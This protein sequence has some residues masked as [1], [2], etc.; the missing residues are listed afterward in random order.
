MINNPFIKKYF[1]N[2]LWLALDNVIKVIG[3]LFV[4]VWVARYLGAESYGVLQY[5]ITYNFMFSALVNIGLGSILVREIVSTPEKENTLM[6]SALGLQLIGASIA[7]CLINITSLLYESD[8]LIQLIIFLFSLQMFANAFQPFT[9]YFQANVISKYN[10]WAESISFLISS[11]V[12]VYFILNEFPVQYIACA[13]LFDYFIKAIL[14]T[15]FFYYIK[16]SL[17]FVFKWEVAISLLKDSWVI[18]ITLFLA[19]VQNRIDQFMIKNMIGIS[20]LGIYSLSADLP[21]Y[22]LLLPTVLINSL[23]P[24]FV[25]LKKNNPNFYN[26]R[27]IQILSAASWASVGVCI[28]GI[29]I[30]EQTIDIIYAGKFEGAYQPFV[31]N[32]WKILFVVQALFV[33]MWLVNENKQKYQL[34]TNSVGTIFNII[35][36]FIFISQYGILGAA[37]S[38]ILTRI[39]ITWISP[40]AFKEIRAI[41]FVTL[42]SLNPILAVRGLLGR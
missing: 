29:L 7:F 39:V 33:N 42:K 24:Y 28:I 16:K 4:G 18:G 2:S 31:L 3:G 40:F 19:M 38:T 20:E 15:Y 12:K 14:K 35:L 27:F 17:N 26:R 34:Y 1:N 22:V 36:N 41:G 37:I 30:G 11:G 32:V 23:M 10:V 25:E 6:G 8:W 13:Y 9:F 21:S 5:G